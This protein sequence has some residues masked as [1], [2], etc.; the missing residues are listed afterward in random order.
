MFLGR[1]GDRTVVEKGLPS[2][3]KEMALGE[4]NTPRRIAA[5]LT[6]LAHESAFEF[7]SREHGD[8]RLYGGRGFIQLTGVVNYHDAGTYLGVGLVAAPD[9]AMSLDWSAKC[10][11]WY[12]TKARNCNA[13]ADNLQIGKINA[14]IG[15]PVGDGTEDTARCDSF[16]LAMRH[17]TG[18]IPAGISRTR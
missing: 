16:E 12:W 6:T 7:N 11:R 15:Y 14:A 2:L 18:S 13:L 17:L 1:V 4:I 10:A 8:T 5:F 3:L 9:L